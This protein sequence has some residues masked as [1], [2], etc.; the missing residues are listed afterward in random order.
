[1]FF[2]NLSLFRFSEAVA[3]SLA[4]L[5]THLEEKRLRPCGPLEQSTRGFVSPHGRNAETLVHTVGAYTMITVGGEDK[6]L[7]GSVVNEELAAR[8]QKITEEQ[9]RRVGAKE[10]KRMKDEVL[11]DLLPRAFVRPFRMYAYLDRKNGWLVVDTSSRKSA[12]ETVSE[13]REAIGTFPATP[14]APE[15]ST[16]TLMTDWVT[17]GKLPAGLALG[18]ECELRDPAES[19]AVVRCRRQDLET[20]EVREHLKNGKQVFQLGLTFDDRISFVLGEDMVVRKFRFLDQV[21]DEL[22]DTEADSAAA[23]LDSR[24]A[25]MTLEVERLLGKLDEWFGLP[26]PQDR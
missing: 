10:R 1:M 18:D 21:L 25:L 6:L 12:E 14:M 19:G 9:G 20:D 2:R 17:H 4:E 26:R 13:I 3:E 7:P 8:L 16:R 11:T 15:E 23:E 5:E 24:M 22:G